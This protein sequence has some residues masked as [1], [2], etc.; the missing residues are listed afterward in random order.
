MTLFFP[1]Q[2][3]VKVA[4]GLDSVKLHVSITNSG[5]VALGHTKEEL[6]N[7]GPSSQGYPIANTDGPVELQWTGDLWMVSQTGGTGLQVSVAIESAGNI[8]IGKRQNLAGSSGATAGFSGG[9]SGGL[10]NPAQTHGGSHLTPALGS[11][12]HK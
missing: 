12:L 7:F 9:L 8:R 11:G 6:G 5:Q 4:T 3:P 10:G 2:I 1:D